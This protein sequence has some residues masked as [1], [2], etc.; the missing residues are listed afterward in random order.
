MTNDTVRFAVDLAIHDGMVGKFEQVARTMTASSQ[1]EPGTLTY[2]WYISSDRKRCRLI[3]IYRDA[4][5]AFAH[6]VGPV[7]K[8]LVPQLLA[9]SKVTA[10]EVYGD[11]GPKAT[12]VL[13]GFGAEIFK[14]SQG[15]TR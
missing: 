6:L 7:V 4:E 5:A 1:K 8:E 13:V 3:E 11:P 10:F 14:P 12:E 15:F 9:V 2:F